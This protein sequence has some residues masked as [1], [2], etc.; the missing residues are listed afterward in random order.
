MRLTDCSD[1]SPPPLTGR[2]AQAVARKSRQAIRQWLLH[3]LAHSYSYPSEWLQERTRLTGESRK[4]FFGFSLVTNKGD[5]FFWAA[6][7]PGDS[8][9]AE[10]R[11]REQ[12]R[13]SPFARI[14]ISTD[15]TLKG[16]RVLRQ[17]S[18]SEE[19]DFIPDLEVFN[20][21]AEATLLRL[22]RAPGAEG[23]G[24]DRQL[25]PI[26]EDLED[27]FFEAH[28]HIRDID[29]LHADEALDELCKILYAKLYDEEITPAGEPYTLQR[30]PFGTVE[31]FAAIVRRTYQD[32]SEYDV[33]AF[34]LRVPGYDRSRGVFHSPIR[35]SSPA[36]VKVVEGLESYWLRR[37]SIDVKGR[38]RSGAA[39]WVRRCGQAW[40][41]TL[42]RWKSF[43]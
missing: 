1:V 9:L 36:L 24:H 7:E 37:S 2:K 38:G 35:L 29:G 39:S 12:L 28:S 23:A 13:M 26:S 20:R 18:N 14:G 17:R 42:R 5:P 31:E 30:G 4:G 32:A 10:N 15:G 22:F 43:T 27:V 33:R 40:D 6:I 21:P 8:T 41:N 3:E 16:T 25:E 19:C 34:S 11:L